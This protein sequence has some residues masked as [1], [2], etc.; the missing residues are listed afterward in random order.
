M[1]HSA[2]FTRTSEHAPTDEVSKNAQLLLRAGFLHKDMAGVYS[3][4][5]LG[6]RVFNRI[7]GVIREEMNTL[8]GQEV[9]LASLQAQRVWQ[10]SGRWDDAVMDVW[11]K[12][13]LKGG[14]TLGLAA[15]HEEPLTELMRQHIASYKDLPAYVYQF[16]TKFRNE[17]RAKSGIMRTREFVMKDLYSFNTDEESFRIFYEQCKRVGLGPV[18][19]RTFASGGSFSEFSDEFQTV[20]ESGED[21]IYVH[22]GRSIALNKEVYTDEVLNKLGI[23]RSE[24]VEKKSI[25]VGNIFPL[26]HKFSEALGLKY[27]T[28]EGKDELVYM[29][30]YGI[31]PGRLMGTI[32]EL[33]ADHKGLVWPMAIA[34][35]AF[36]IV[37]LGVHEDVSKAAHEL[38]ALCVESGLDVLFDERDLRAGQKFA[39]SDLLGI[40]YRILVSEKTVATGG[41]EVV[42]RADGTTQF[43]SEVDCVEHM[44]RLSSDRI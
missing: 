3:Y 24:L 35:F 20:C 8:G 10:A 15:T 17:L 25:E 22:E 29:G 34:P 43:I 38:Y 19:Y 16:Q 36:H 39:E 13:E 18:T 32:A 44:R 26:G 33:Y 14:S 23:D 30:S 5:P 40:P 41:Y 1:K 37:Q 42:C 31:G 2:L 27:R 28:A 12:T 4:L 11:F 9:H 21:T 6:L 7:V